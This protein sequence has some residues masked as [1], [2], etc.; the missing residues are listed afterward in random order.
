LRLLLLAV[1]VLV[2]GAAH[3]QDDE[4]GYLVKEV[5][6]VG[7]RSYPEATI[8][9]ALGIEIGEFLKPMGFERRVQ[10]VFTSYGIMVQK[11]RHEPVP[12]GVKLVI[13]VVEFE[14][15][16]EP[17]F[18]GNAT[19]KVSKL[20]EWAGLAD[21]AQM[22]LYEADRVAWRLKQA[23]L[24]QGFHWVEV[25]WVPGGG[26]EESAA[27]DV[28]FVI[29]EGPKVRVTRVS[30]EGNDSLPDTGVLFWKGGLRHLSKAKTKGR[31]VFSWWGGVFDEE[32]LRADLLAMRQVYRDRGWLDA[33]VELE[34]PE[35]NELRNRVH[36][37]I[38]VDEGRLYRVKELNIEALEVERG[39]TGVTRETPVPLLFDDAALRAE[40]E[41]LPGKPFE[42]ARMEHDERAL[43]RYYGERGYLESGLFKDPDYPGGWKFLEPVVGFDP[44]RAEVS[45]T[46]RLRQGR[47][48]F[49]RRVDVS[50]NR[51]TSDKV[52]RREISAFPG[53]LANL[54]ELERSR[55]RITG[56]S[57]FTDPQD[58]RH[59]DPIF[60]LKDV[61][62]DPDA[63][64]V[65]FIVEEGRVVDL[66]LSGGV[67]S[68]SGLVGIL[69]L[70]MRNFS[71]ARLP[72]GPW[73]MFGEVY[74][75]EAFHGNGETF[76]LEA[77]P[78]SE[79]SI[80]RIAY[81]HPDVFGSHVDRWGAGFDGTKRDRRFRSHDEERTRI[82]LDISH[83]FEQGDVSLRVGP[84]FQS[85]RIDNLDDGD[86][87]S[88]LLATPEESY[89][90]G[91]DFDVRW[92]KLDNRRYPRNG[93]YVRWGTTVF[94]GPFGGDNDLA[95][96]ELYYD[97]YHEL[98]SQEDDARSGLYAGVV[99]GVARPYGDTS[100]THYSERYFLGG[101]SNMRGF[102][103][104]GVGPNEGDYALGGQTMLRGSLEYRFPLYSTP[105]PGT[106]RRQEV[107]R[108]AWFL[109]WGILDPDS[110]ALDTDELRASAGFSVGLTQP[111]PITFSLGW[112]LREGEGDVTEVFSFRLSLR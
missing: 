27:T 42:K 65:E 67:A 21:R 104:R 59:P 64:D 88:T 86:L 10:G 45:V 111:L 22:Y 26:D 58:S 71:A 30:I 96:S 3:T 7:L 70:S 18:L 15:D 44:E 87:P 28:I 43:R 68:D 32:H 77:S 37:H 66:Q 90:K 105:I 5:E 38:R 19:Y 106:S 49:L 25:E 78:G 52:V 95:K 53:E 13:P 20:R 74:R 112:P 81:Q 80:W 93:Q 85:V 14:V 60:V 36:L 75:K 1:C 48:R 9:S 12:G 101:S 102:G 35:F 108:G 62:G 63:V 4:D 98:G 54:V 73:A 97:W 29:R 6:F 51:H 57:F 16:L 99:A 33:M 34:D 107:F 46:Y 94:G 39:P 40:L 76:A 56:S 103:F 83:F 89:F 91:L 2:A 72:S 47:Q 55:A 8:R 109:D 61:P 50:G 31:G 110:F 17:R 24:R 79:V 82:E 69:S 84:V 23:Y 41:L 92:S 11:P 100:F